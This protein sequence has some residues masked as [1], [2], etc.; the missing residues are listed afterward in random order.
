MHQAAS[1][2]A[3]AHTAILR[4]KI[5]LALRYIVSFDGMSL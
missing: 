4:A 3:P 5:A 2:N 1:R